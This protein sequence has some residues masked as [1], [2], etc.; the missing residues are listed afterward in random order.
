MNKKHKSDHSFYNK[1]NFS[2]NRR[3][4]Y[5]IESNNLNAQFFI[6]PIDSYDQLFPDFRKPMEIGGFSSTKRLESLKNKN[7]LN[8]NE[9]STFGVKYL[10]NLL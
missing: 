6:N 5:V 1:Q 3:E 10:G 7:K 2:S 9:N 8:E 4:N